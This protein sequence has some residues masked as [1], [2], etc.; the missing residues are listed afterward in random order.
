MK[1]R[2]RH[3]K[4]QRQRIYFDLVAANFLNMIEEGNIDQVTAGLAQNTIVVKAHGLRL[5]VLCGDATILQLLLE[6]PEIDINT[7]SYCYEPYDGDVS[8]A[9][10]Y[11]LLDAA[12]FHRR[13]DLA[14]Q[15]LKF[16][17]EIRLTDTI[18]QRVLNQAIYDG[19]IEFVRLLYY[20]LQ[21]RE[22]R[23]DVEKTLTISLSKFSPEILKF[24]LVDVCMPIDAVIL[25]KL[26]YVTLTKFLGRTKQKQ[27]VEL[28]FA[29]V[30]Q[31]TIE[32]A[33]SAG[34]YEILKIAVLDY[35]I[36]DIAIMLFRYIDKDGM[37]I[38]LEIMVSV[39]NLRDVD[40]WHTVSE[41]VME[42]PF[43]LQTVMRLYG[44]THTLCTCLCICLIEK[45]YE[46]VR[47]V[48]IRLPNDSYARM[49]LSSSVC[50]Q[51]E[52][53]LQLAKIQHVKKMT[54]AKSS[55]SWMTCSTADGHSFY[56]DPW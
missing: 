14:Y 9:E 46:A 27:I 36:H 23:V 40:F 45:E 30:Q 12:V 34:N 55:Y 52:L 37:P 50:I 11:T 8:A 10:T 25:S 24:F 17:K 16:S 6:D 56:W 31:Q 28:L 15:I 38:A 41:I 20:E 5:A 2:R 22:I 43:L 29:S 54:L 48:L 4:P 44:E 7:I 53:H 3:R 13:P 1:R 51:T 49:V 18:G 33:L 39:V 26:L 42:N 21:K 35:Y 32:Q 19:S 47:A